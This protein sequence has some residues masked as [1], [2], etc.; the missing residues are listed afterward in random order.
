MKLALNMYVIPLH[1][2]DTFLRNLK[3]KRQNS[4]I[5]EII[6]S[7]KFTHIYPQLPEFD[8]IYS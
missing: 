8:Y 2:V 1:Y 6:Y 5:Q 7:N 3:Q 4:L